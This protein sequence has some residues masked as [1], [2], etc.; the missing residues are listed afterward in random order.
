MKGRTNR[1]IF[2]ILLL[3][4]I[5]GIADGLYIHLKAAAAQYLLKQAW[6]ETVAR[7]QPVKPW[8]WADTWPVARLRLDRLGIDCIVLAGDSGEVLAFGPGH[9]SRSAVPATEG[10]CV[11]V[12]HR[13]TSFS[14]LKNIETGDVFSLQNADD[15]ERKYQIVSTSVKKSRELF[16]QETVTPWL[17][18]VTCYPFDTVGLE[19]DLRL[20]VFARE[21][22]TRG[23]K[24]AA[25]LPPAR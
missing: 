20:V 4:G 19:K 17:T 16:V 14:F 21:I 24:L 23:E 9:L 2:C 18:L 25:H 7:K 22:P 11:L 13:D 6:Q 15:K 12:G 5:L 10:N 3:A 1:Y 8:P